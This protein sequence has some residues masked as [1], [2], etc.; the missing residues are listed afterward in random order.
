MYALQV[1]EVTYFYFHFEIV[2]R[3]GPC[4]DQDMYLV[5]LDWLILHILVKNLTI[6]VQVTFMPKVDLKTC[7]AAVCD[8]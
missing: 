6:L 7:I 5:M 3:V 8:F 2:E 1:N 4:P